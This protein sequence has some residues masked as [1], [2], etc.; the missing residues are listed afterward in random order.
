MLRL[1]SALS[2]SFVLAACGGED[3]LV[4][5]VCTDR[6]AENVPPSDLVDVLVV[7]DTTA[8]MTEHAAEVRALAG[9]LDASLQTVGRSV[10]G[11]DVH[12]AV[13]T[14]DL[15]A[16]GVPGC[17]TT[18]DGA[19]FVGGA[20]CGLDGAFLRDTANGDARAQN[21]TGPREDAIACLLAEAA[22]TCPVSQ[23][24]NAAV[25]AL[26]AAAT[27]N[28]GFHRPGALLTVLVVTDGDDCSLTSAGALAV[29]S[30]NDVE[31]D[32]DYQCFAK[33]SSCSP[34]NPETPGEHSACV[35][36]GD[37]G[38][39]D[40]A[41][42]VRALESRGAQWTF[43]GVVAASP[44]PVVTTG[45][46]GTRLAP[47]CTTTG[48]MERGAAPRL[49]SINADTRGRSV[50]TVC[51]GALD[52]LSGAWVGRLATDLGLP[53]LDPEIDRSTCTARL[54]ASPDPGAEVLAA[55]VPAC[56]GGA[57]V[58]Q[59]CWDLADVAGPDCP[60]GVIVD[61]G[62]VVPRGYVEVTCEVPC[63]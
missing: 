54:L 33:G 7:L 13:V 45:P 35:P 58:G 61:N 25:R 8:S 28:A 6:R 18:G 1:A 34:G 51:D 3:E 62:G 5:Q 19:A 38:F 36:R 44:N 60:Y 21:F 20:R 12:L 23:P 55:S 10:A 31:G 63:E 56:A 17:D 37:L 39:A 57:G 11:M 53:C 14:S 15:G 49:T 32:V 30:G 42:L 22:S 29:A 52:A 59:L 43:V 26:D 50:I 46:A 16:A 48:G 27:A 4:P 47:A 9:T 40:P 41:T 24:L 2:L